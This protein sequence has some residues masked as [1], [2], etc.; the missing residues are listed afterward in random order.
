MASELVKDLGDGWTI[1]R[2]P[3]DTL[4]LVNPDDWEVA[5]VRRGEMVMSGTAPVSCMRALLDEA[6]K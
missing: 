3:N 4:A 1:R 2:G 6:S 5:G